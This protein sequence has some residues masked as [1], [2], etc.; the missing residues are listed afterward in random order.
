MDVKPMKGMTSISH[1]TTGFGRKELSH[2]NRIRKDW[3][4]RRHSPKQVSML[5]LRDSNSRTVEEL[6]Q[7][8]EKFI[9]AR[10]AESNFA[11]KWQTVSTKNFHD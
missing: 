4:P 3:R 11:K 6:Q 10:A 9:A 8:V 5:A 7:V 1:L 2:F